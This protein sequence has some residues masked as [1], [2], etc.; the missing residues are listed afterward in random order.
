MRDVNEGLAESVDRQGEVARHEAAHAVL[1]SLVGV[2]IERVTL[3][4]QQ[5]DSNVLFRRAGTTTWQRVAV[6][7]A[8]AALDRAGGV[9][10]TLTLRDRADALAE[11]ERRGLEPVGMVGGV[12]DRLAGL[13]ELGG[14]YRAVEAVADA[15]RRQGELSGA[16]VERIIAW[17]FGSELEACRAEA[18]R[19]CR[20][21]VG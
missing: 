3:D 7:T 2:T 5:R 21:A 9:F 17:E 18:R 8:P 12:I 11:L 20:R 19:L 6:L 15:L 4:R 14:V 10:S 13:Y 16:D 1:A